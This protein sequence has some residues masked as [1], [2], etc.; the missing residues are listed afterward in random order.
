[1]VF[2]STTLPGHGE[3]RKQKMVFMRTLMLFF[4]LC[5]QIWSELQEYIFITERPCTGKPPL[6]C[7]PKAPTLY[8]YQALS[9]LYIE[10][11]Q[12]ARLEEKGQNKE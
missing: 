1:M 9:R 5:R 2:Y 6:F 3:P 7:S 11:E 8:V 4:L 10:Y 12:I